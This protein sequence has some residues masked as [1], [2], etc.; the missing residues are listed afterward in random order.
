[1]QEVVLSATVSQ[2]AFTFD[3]AAFAE[4]IA[5]SL[6]HVLKCL[7][8]APANEVGEVVAVTIG[9]YK[10]T[11]LHNPVR[12]SRDDGGNG[13]HSDENNGHS[14]ENNSH[15]A[16]NNG[17]C[18]DV[19]IEFSRV[20]AKIHDVLQYMVNGDMPGRVS[21]VVDLRADDGSMVQ[22]LAEVHCDTDCTDAASRYAVTYRLCSAP[23][24]VYHTYCV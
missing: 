19:P 10:C 22:Y 12:I 17:N 8:A 13:G 21:R 6:V 11:I 7:A 2:V 14:A 5:D 3:M 16:E 9:E 20:P 1:M 18:D 24:R 15:S 4:P 23:T